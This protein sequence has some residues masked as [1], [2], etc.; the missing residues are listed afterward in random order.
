MVCTLQSRTKGDTRLLKPRLAKFDLVS[1]QS[2]YQFADIGVNG[3]RRRTLQR[4]NRD[5]PRGALQTSA[6]LPETPV[7]ARG[8]DVPRTPPRNSTGP[9]RNNTMNSIQ[10]IGKI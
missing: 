3:A 2:I 7:F 6:S 1:V 10:S 5:V 4:Q 9:P 8:C